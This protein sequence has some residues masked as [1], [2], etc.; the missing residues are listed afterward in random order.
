MNPEAFDKTS[1]GAILPPGVRG[2]VL[3]AVITLA[4]VSTALF[5]W[6]GPAILLDLAAMAKFICF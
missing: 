5:V 4:A 3:A 2:W 6:R 1:D